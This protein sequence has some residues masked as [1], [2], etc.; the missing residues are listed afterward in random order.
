MNHQ[1][2]KKPLLSQ[3]YSWLLGVLLLSGLIMIVTHFVELE[4]FTNLA[5]QAEPKWLMIALLLQIT[6]YFSAAGAWYV[7]LKKMGYR[8]SLWSLIPLGI[9]KLFTEQSLPTGGMSGTAFFIAALKKRGIPNSICI[10]TLIVSLVAYYGAY[11]LAAV[12]AVVLLYFYHKLNEWIILISLIFA[13]VAVGI[14][15][16]T[17]WLR[18]IGK[19]EL[20]AILLRIPGLSGLMR[21]IGNS[22]VGMLHRPV[23]IFAIAFFHG[24]VFLMD[25]ATLWVMLKVVGANVSFWTAFPSF[26]FASMV[27][28]VG[29]IPLGLGTF[30]IT[31]VTLL[32]MMGVSMEA[33]LSA[34]LLLRGF[35]VWLPMLPGMLMTRWTLR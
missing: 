21:A 11:L 29:P 34:T 32:H 6:T 15:T 24:T 22:S 31:S 30:E 20:P 2:S 1:H 23:L 5:R 28:T 33:A 18:S 14:P 19:K 9:A 8:Q 16:G 35:T 7:P 26:I 3:I 27:A 25:S 10:S 13:I 17:L 12:A 4:H